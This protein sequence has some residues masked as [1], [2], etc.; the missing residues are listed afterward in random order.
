V[1]GFI[2]HHSPIAEALRLLHSADTARERLQSNKFDGRSREDHPVAKS[3]P[4]SESSPNHC[5]VCGSA[6]WVKASDPAVEAP[7]SRCGYLLWFRPIP[8]DEGMTIEIRNAKYFEPEMIDRLS[9]FATE[10]GLTRV[11]LDL[12]DIEFIASAALSKLINL[13]KK[14]GHEGSL[15]LRH[16]HPDL[17]EVFR[18]TRLDQILEIG[19]G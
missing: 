12:G 2:I 4:A 19:P 5:P 16:V 3:P 6:I 17:L 10:R 15:K 13:K 18:I 8:G 14:L 7:C 1:I 11:V 9:S